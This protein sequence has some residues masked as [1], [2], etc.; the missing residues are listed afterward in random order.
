MRQVLHLS[1]PAW[2]CTLPYLV[3]P[4]PDE[5]LAGLLL[6]CD[7]INH[8]PCRTT[9]T[10]LLSP[11]PEKFHRCWR[12]ANPHLIVIQPNS[13]NLDYLAEIL[14][15]EVRV[16]LA[17]TYHQELARLYETRP[18]PKLL[19]ASFSLQVCPQCIAE[20]RLLRRVLTLPQITLC[21]QHRIA[22]QKHCQCGAT[23]SLFQKLTQPFACF[24]CGRDWKTLPLIATSPED[25]IREQRILSWYA[26]FFTYGTPLLF[27]QAVLLANGIPVE[28]GETTL[29]LRMRKVRRHRFVD[30]PSSLS[31]LVSLLV[32]RNL[33]PSHLINL[34]PHDANM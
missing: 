22:L 9:L 27:Q 23:L 24:Q 12:T 10:H 33:F 14:D 32:M 29:P 20:K 30:E 28:Q 1:E 19:R 8:W 25:W 13:L 6:R 21:P 7:E 5:W 16:L 34:F 3:T 11:G 26:F 18:H 31:A 15:L 17:T 2:S 4:H